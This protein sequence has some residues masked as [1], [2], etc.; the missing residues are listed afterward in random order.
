MLFLFSCL[1]VLLAA[2]IPGSLG[3]PQ[4]RGEIKP[5]L[6]I[7]ARI[8]TTG[9]AN[10]VE[11]DRARA[12]YLRSGRFAP[13]SEARNFRRTSSFS[14]QNTGVHYFSSR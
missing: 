13:T 7:L 8:N 12:E 5:S 3:L 10:L 4:A 1:F 11:A 2:G 14:V 9:F 6:S